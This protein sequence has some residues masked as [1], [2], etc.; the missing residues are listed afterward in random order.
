MLLT[1]RQ[2]I[3]ISFNVTQEVKVQDK[4]VVVKVV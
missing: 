3:N 1:A 2:S 4:W